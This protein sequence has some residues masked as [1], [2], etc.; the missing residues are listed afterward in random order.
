MSFPSMSRE[1]KLRRHQSRGEDRLSFFPPPLLRLSA[2]FIARRYARRGL[3]RRPRSRRSFFFSSHIG[4]NFTRSVRTVRH[5]T[6][7]FGRISRD[8]EPRAPDDRAGPL[9]FPPVD[10]RKKKGTKKKSEHAGVT[11]KRGDSF[12]RRRIARI[13]NYFGGG[14][15]VGNNSPRR[16]RVSR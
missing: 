6:E 8:N 12:P 16:K 15:G 9:F 1:M 14:R 4:Q 2:R 7:S 3:E 5:G 13:K 11:R 10:D